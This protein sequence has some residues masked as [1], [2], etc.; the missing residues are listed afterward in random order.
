M[1]INFNVIFIGMKILQSGVP[2]CGNFWLY[3]IIQQ[4]LIRSG[5]SNSSFIEKQP[6]YSLAKDWDLNFP[7]QS[8]IDVLEITDLQLSYRISRI[9]QMPIDKIEQYILQTSHVW[10]HSPV[11]KRSGEVFINFDKIIY[12]IRDPRDRAL[13]AA[14]YYCSDYMLKYFPQE[15]RDPDKFLEK[16]FDKLMHEWVWHVFD[17]LRLNAQY[18][19]HILFYEKFLWEFQQELENLLR[20]LEIS[21]D[22]G[23]RSSIEETV[24][25]EK[26]KL[27]NPK[28]LNKGT[29]GYWKDKL[30]D[31]HIAKAEVIAGPL[32]KALGYSSDRG[33]PNI[34]S[35]PSGVDFDILK[36]EIMETQKPLYQI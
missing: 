8:R 7:E 27:K 23:I 11:C 30:S 21:L 32:L 25:F 9:F 14:K 28:H 18:K 34:K 16:N 26:L 5:R 36:Q 33:Q 31:E 35:H 19:I 17:Y 12:I 22:S 29:Y 2:K 10:T 15:E 24:S 20:Y 1:L 3:Q 4:I 13:S 6:V